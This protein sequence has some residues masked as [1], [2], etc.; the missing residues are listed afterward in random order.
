M[1][2]E[3]NIQSVC[4]QSLI[5]IKSNWPIINESKL[6]RFIN[7]ILRQLCLLCYK[8]KDVFKNL[9]IQ[10]LKTSLPFCIDLLDLFESYSIYHETLISHWWWSR[11]QLRH[12]MKPWYP[13]EESAETSWFSQFIFKMRIKKCWVQ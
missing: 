8:V 4:F 11:K 12:I 2:M 10:V 5:H 3:L 9:P 13:I 1:I 6:N 7:W